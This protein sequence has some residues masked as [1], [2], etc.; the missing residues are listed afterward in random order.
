MREVKLFT[1]AVLAYL[2]TVAFAG[3]FIWAALFPEEG[4][5]ALFIGFL[6][7]FIGALSTAMVEKLK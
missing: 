2:A 1:Y 6:S 3:S 5:R 4:F 7:L